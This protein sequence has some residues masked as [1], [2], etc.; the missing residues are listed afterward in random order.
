MKLKEDFQYKQI[1]FGEHL[2]SKYPNK[3]V[4]IVEAEKTA[5]IASLYFPEFVWLGCNSKSWLNATR[6]GWLGNR[7]II[8]YPDADGFD[9]WQEIASDATK[10]GL[11]VKVSSLIDRLVFI[12]V[13]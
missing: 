11:T 1:Y 6:L 12:I 10:Q 4:A 3:P 2:V 8:L 7:Q 9:L 5:I 13:I